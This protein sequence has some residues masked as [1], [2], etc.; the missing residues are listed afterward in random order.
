MMLR[1]I[2]SS[3]GND[4]SRAHHGSPSGLRRRFAGGLLRSARALLALVVGLA[5][6]APRARE[7]A[8]PPS[9]PDRLPPRR[10][11]R[12]S[13]ETYSAAGARRGLL[14]SA[15]AL[16]AAAL[17]ALCGGLALPATAQAQT[18]EELVSNIDL[19]R[20]TS[21]TLSTDLYSQR[22]TTGPSSSSY[23][24]TSIEMKVH[25]VRTSPTMAVTV[26]SDN[27]GA[28]G[29]V[30]ATLT[31]PT[32][33]V[34]GNN[35]FTAPSGTT[36][37]GNNTRYHVVVGGTDV[38]ISGV[39]S[40]RQDGSQGWTIA[41]GFRPSAGTGWG[42][43]HN[44]VSLQIR[45]NGPQI[46]GLPPPTTS[47]G[48]VR[49]DGN[50]LWIFF[51]E[52]LSNMFPPKSALTVTAGG[53]PVT[54]G[55]IKLNTS[56]TLEL[57]DFSP[58]IGADQTV[59]LDYTDPTG[60]NDINAIQDTHGND[61][62]SFSNLV[63]SNDSTITVP[64]LSAAAVPADGATVTLTFSENLDFPTAFSSAIRNAFT[65]TV[66]GTE[67]PTTDFAVSGAHAD[68]TM[69][70]TIGE[71]QA[72]IV[73]YDRSDAGTNALD[74]ADGNEVASLTTGS[75][76]I[77]AVDNN[78]TVAPAT[79]TSATVNASGAILNI[80]FDKQI[81]NP[82][83]FAALFSLTVDG[84]GHGVGNLQFGGGDQSIGFILPSPIF[85]GQAVVLSYAKPADS[86]GLTT[87]DAEALP[88]ASFTTG[89]DGVPAVMNNSA[90]IAPPALDLSHANSKVGT[91]G[92]SLSIVFDGP[93]ATDNAPPDS[94]FSVTVDGFA[95]G[96]G[97][98][99]LSSS[100]TG[101]SFTL[102]ALSPK[103]R[104]GET[105]EVTYT[106]PT[107]GDDTNALQSPTGLDVPTFTVT[108]KNNSTLTMG[109]PRPPTAL[110]AAALGATIV[111]LA[112][113]KPGNNGGS[114]I[115]GYKVE[116][117]TDG[118]TWTDLEDD[119][120]STDTWYR[121]SGLSN[122]NTRH[123]RVSAINANGTSPASVSASAT[124]MTGGAHHAVPDPIH[125]T[126]L[127]SAEMTAGD[128]GGRT[129]GYSDETFG[130]PFGAL[131][132]TT[133][134][135][136]DGTMLTVGL[137]RFD[138]GDRRI[139]F[140]L[141]DGLGAGLF[142]LH[143]GTATA[144]FPER[145]TDNSLSTSGHSNPGW[146]HGDTV[147]VRLVLAT[148]PGKPT[149]LTATASGTT[150]IDLA[151]T[152]P[153]DGGRA[154][155]G[156][157]IEVSEDGSAGI[158]SDRVAD[159][160]N[161]GIWSDRVADTGNDDT[162]YSHTGL[163]AGSMRHYRVSAINAVGPSEASDVVS[164][165]TAT[166]C[167]PNP[168][169]L[170]CGVVTPALYSASGFDLAYGFVDSATDTGALSETE[171]SVGMNDYAIDNVTVGL[172]TQ[173]GTLYFGLTSVLTAAD[174]AKLVLHVGSDSFAFSVAAGPDTSQDYRWIDS[175][176]DWSSTP[177]VTLRL[178]EAVAG[179]A[180]PT[181]FRATA[182]ELQVALTWDA[183]ASGSGV[184]RHE[185]QYKTSGEY[186]DD[187][188]QI[189]D[190]APGEAN[191][192][193]FT[194]TGLT[195][196]TAHTFQLRA[197]SADGNS[198]AAEDGPVTPMAPAGPDATLSALVVNDGSRDLTLSP[199]FTPGA[200]SYTTSVANRTDKV[201][202]TPTTNHADATIEYLN[203]SDMTLAD[204]DLAKAEFQVTLVE[205]DNVVKVKVTAADG[206][207]TRTYTVTVT[208]RAA[209]APGV[210]GELRLTDEEPYTHPDGYEGVA[211][212]VEIFHNG[213][214][215]TVC[216]DGFSR[217]TTSR[218]I[219]ELDDDG[220]ETA[221][222]TESE[223]ANDAPALL[224]QA[225][226]YETG[227]Y[228]SG[229]GRPG[230]SQPSALASYSPVGGSYPPGDPLPIWLDDMT[231]A[232]GDADQGRHPLP[233]PLAHCAYAGWGLHNCT[234]REDAGVPLLERA[235]E[236]RGRCAGA[237][238][239]VRVA[240]GAPRRLVPGQGSGGVQRGD[241]GEPGERG[242][243]RGAGRGRPG[244][245]GAPG[246]QPA[247]RGRGGAFGG[248]FGWRA[249]RRGE[250]VGVRDRAGL[251]RG[252]DDADRRGA[253]VRRGGRDLHGGRA[254]AVGGDRD[255]G[256][257]SGPGS[258]DGG[259]P[260][261]AGGA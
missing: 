7:Q 203:A 106:D 235:G 135:R 19:S 93:I 215:G 56:R 74:D 102:A 241:R 89:E 141:D 122:G 22:F 26:R 1:A 50:R 149:G 158:W 230:P 234:H 85:T 34:V 227:E 130:T 21:L 68:L 52:N 35:T 190:S 38:V 173:L 154:V 134:D 81:N 77:P 172:G 108:V 210:E 160:G 39:S 28:P 178:R 125:G 181:N 110:T 47:A 193:S 86:V 174:K 82:L 16:A 253:S 261:R 137:I 98:V 140:I 113:T 3:P 54:I 132:P 195:G 257:G 4:G 80:E 237:E 238:G 114:A 246:G 196:G 223:H 78:S 258:A 185:Y 191:E 96:F 254:F 8:D 228:A 136:G 29:S 218:F 41:N 180:A 128:V 176:L 33:L 194:V 30:H 217:E 255:D 46:V 207:T 120:E 239:A 67:R 88:V 124:T 233:A 251:G 220:N 171:F 94:A 73:S 159:T 36:L 224:C 123:Y 118:S 105:V 95:I 126:P 58:L 62:S 243:A 145:P 204:A 92:S 179:P 209:D 202:V 175:G 121:H 236:R 152:A 127:W 219:V 167:T 177:S 72:V 169:D 76:A 42:P 87:N 150:Q 64:K 252:P 119:T 10:G 43:V 57:T 45:V 5:M 31:S 161:A 162:T 12:P 133:F 90:A 61:A 53:S 231:C 201:T 59:T 6:T 226:G 245:V 107:A 232:A 148:A 44:R 103:V 166:T 221:N 155:T 60:G 187:W 25:S 248:P 206:A 104:Q 197:V 156:Y 198:T 256:R 15:R 63:V 183:P 115:T 184:T 37:N 199:S 153:S 18:F 165:T 138:S 116:V 144:E 91:G 51:N 212:R 225:M 109:V 112:W 170:W 11:G 240:A 117:S 208:R 259:V 214:W 205:G 14:R 213:R 99:L 24:L 40:D 9:P 84:V 101:A 32:P 79:V 111:E 222:V 242:R 23:P 2:A 97:A 260:R 65:V 151:W 211:G 163:A 131:T 244:D 17:L 200:T 71:D 247:G 186:L 249:G 189:A 157:R 100:T 55:R 188:K 20:D 143:L 70:D 66:D 27:S 75:G 142:N 69:S 48:Q 229:Y 147:E 164:D 192:A 182:G 129:I 250:R 146:S 139:S 216:D 13:A 83:G 168:G 49:Q